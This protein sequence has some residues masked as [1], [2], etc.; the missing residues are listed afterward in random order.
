LFLETEGI[1]MLK[2]LINF[3]KKESHCEAAWDSCLE[4][5]AESFGMFSDAV[6]SFHEEKTLDVGIYKRDRIINKFERKV[7]R[8]IVTHL[9]VSNN[10]DVNTA[11]VLTAIVIDIERIGDYTKNI[12]ELAATHPGVFRGGELNKEIIQIEADVHG[13]Y[14]QLIPSMEASDIDRARQILGDHQILADRVEDCIQDLVTGKALASDSGAAVVAALY[15]RYLKRISAHL[16]NVAS[17]VV[18]PYY[19]IGFREK[20]N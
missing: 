13:M 7:R 16:K 19:R 15:L 5:M 11:L 1:S 8:D 18:N 12:V 14:K 10:P 9:A 20:D 6:R 17:S 4:M 2:N 3:W